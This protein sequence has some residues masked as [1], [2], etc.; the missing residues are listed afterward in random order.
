MGPLQS[1]R[2]WV[3]FASV[4]CGFFLPLLF[5][6][7]LSWQHLAVKITLGQNEHFK[8]LDQWGVSLL[9]G[10]FFCNSCLLLIVAICIDT[11]Q[12]FGTAVNILLNQDWIVRILN[13]SKLTLFFLRKWVTT[14]RN[15]E[16]KKFRQQIGEIVCLLLKTGIIFIQLFNLLDFI[17]KVVFAVIIKWDSDTGKYMMSCVCIKMPN[18]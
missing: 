18:S 2:V 16:C 8:M 10:R 14:T 17:S 3:F 11:W 15:C 9:P 13:S 5:I 12:N 7:S 1:G 6:S 4:I